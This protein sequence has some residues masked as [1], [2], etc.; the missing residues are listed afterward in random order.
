MRYKDIGFAQ[1]L[2]YVDRF[3]E[4]GIDSD[5]IVHPSTR[6]IRWNVEELLKVYISC[7]VGVS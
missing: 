6:K 2:S 4:K 3:E 5:K 7:F 1:A